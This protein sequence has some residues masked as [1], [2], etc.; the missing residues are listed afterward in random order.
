M[1]EDWVTGD[2]SEGLEI[3]AAG[4]RGQ[5]TLKMTIRKAALAS[6]GI[7]LTPAWIW[8]IN[9]ERWDFVEAVMLSDRNVPIAGIHNEIVCIIRKAVE[10]NSSKNVI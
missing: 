9:G 3:D 8:L 7:V 2:G 6:A 10:L 5:G 1:L 4:L